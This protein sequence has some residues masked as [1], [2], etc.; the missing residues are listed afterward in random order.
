MG[1]AGFSCLTL[2]PPAA[3]GMVEE[4]GRSNAGVCVCVCDCECASIYISVT[5]LTC[6]SMGVH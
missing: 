6:V 2:I 4:M 3:G 5:M 1:R